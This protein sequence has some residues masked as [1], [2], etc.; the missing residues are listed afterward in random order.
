L[1]NGNSSTED[2][3]YS[4]RLKLEIPSDAVLEDGRDI[5]SVWRLLFGTLFGVGGLENPLR[6]PSSNERLFKRLGLRRF[7]LNV[8]L[9]LLRSMRLS[10]DI[11]IMFLGFT[12]LHLLFS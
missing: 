6:E 11:D 7:L 2:L 5:D 12:L 10:D 8:R 9:G 3:E 4:L 1:S